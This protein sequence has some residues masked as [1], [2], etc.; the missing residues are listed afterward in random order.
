MEFRIL[1]SKQRDRR[2]LDWTES[3]SLFSAAS[4]KDVRKWRITVRLLAVNTRL[5]IPIQDVFMSGNF[6]HT[7][8]SFVPFRA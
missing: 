6:G 5:A 7:Q 4:W 1:P 8:L 2:V 3:T